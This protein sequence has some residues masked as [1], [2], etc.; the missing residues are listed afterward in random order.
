MW[1]A[2]G[3]LLTVWQKMWSLG[4]RLQWP[5]A[6][7]LWLSHTCLS[8]SRVGGPLKA[9]DLPFFGICQ[10]AILCSVSAPVV[11]V[12]CQSLF[13]GKIFLFFF[14]SCLVIPQFGLLCYINPLRL[15]S[16][17]SSLVLTLRTN[18]AARASTQPPL[19][20][21]GSDSLSHFS[22]GNCGQ[23]G[24]L[25]VPPPIMLPS[26]IPELPTDCL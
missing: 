21:G 9:A 25:W 20:A 16:W 24:I 10:G 11:T 14:F 17:H 26:E 22:I 8:A 3:S 19:D 6:F 7:C 18:D 13:M 2:T 1:L 5:L 4:L 12:Q 23:A 15:S